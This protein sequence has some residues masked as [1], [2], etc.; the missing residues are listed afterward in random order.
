MPH[1]CQSCHRSSSRASCC[2]DL[3]AS[4]PTSH[5][6]SPWGHRPRGGIAARHHKNPSATT[7]ATPGTQE[8]VAPPPVCRQTLC[9]L[10][11]PHDVPAP[12]QC[13]TQQREGKE[14]P[15]RWSP[16]WT[17]AHD[18]VL[19]PRHSQQHRFS[20]RIPGGDSVVH[21][22]SQHPRVPG[23]RG[24]VTH[25]WQRGPGALLA[26]PAGRRSVGRGRY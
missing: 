26:F 24:G 20:T 6:G 18:G 17:P 21:P 7:T 14:P 1:P 25:P 10:P 23:P 5:L 15:P 9:H 13:Q 22:V 16:G 11:V 12:P 3:P 4:C 2:S 19:R 8:D